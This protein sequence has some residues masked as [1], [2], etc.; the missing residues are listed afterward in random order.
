MTAFNL[1]SSAWLP[2]IR[3]SGRRE[4]VQPGRITNNLAV[5]PIVDVDFARADFRCAAIEFLIGLLTVAYP[6]GDDRGP[7]W[8]NP[9]SDAE[10]EAAF[11]LFEGV[12]AYDGNGPRAY[13]DYDDFASKQTPVEALLIDYS[14]DI[15]KENVPTVIELIDN[16]SI[17][18]A[19]ADENRSHWANE[20]STLLNPSVDPILN[21]AERDA[22]R[23]S[24]LEFA[25]EQAQRAKT[26]LRAAIADARA[27]LASPQ[28]ASIMNIRDKQLAHSLER[29]R[30][31]KHGPIAPMKYGD[32]TTVL[33]RSEPVVERLYCW[34]NGTSFSIGDSRRIDEENA[35]SLWQACKFDPN[36]D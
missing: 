35:M 32:E 12:F 23:R 2:V 16:D 5:D 24:E 11:A 4:C 18:D 22:M 36:M 29:T 25:D 15:D 27:I 3:A 33:E 6:P 34:V 26:E 20:A 10:L 14:V 30:R 8:T 17:I 13:Q 21:A 19:L 28:L 1:V 9:P 31:E 7:R